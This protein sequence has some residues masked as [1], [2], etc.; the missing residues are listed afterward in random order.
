MEGYKTNIREHGAWLCYANDFAQYQSS[1]YNKTADVN[2]VHDWIIINPFD[3][4][5]TSEILKNITQS[6]PPVGASN[7]VGM[8]FKT[9]RQIT[10]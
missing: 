5:K 8:I 9:D 10:A 3:S 7:V 4:E 2:E 1:C 6:S